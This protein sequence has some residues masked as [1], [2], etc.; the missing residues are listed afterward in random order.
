MASNQGS[1]KPFTKLFSS[2]TSSS[3]WRA[4]NEVRL[5]WITMLAMADKDGEV[6]ASVG[7]LAD[8]AR[9]SRQECLS[10]LHALLSPDE[11]SR[12]KEHDGRRLEE[13][14]GGWRLLNYKKYRDLGRNEDRR[15]YFAEH[16]RKQRAVKSPHCPPL[17]T[18]GPQKSPIAEAEAEAE[19]ERAASAAT[20]PTPPASPDEKKTRNRELLAKALRREGLPAT[21]E[22]VQE[23]G[24]MLLGAGGATSAEDALKRLGI[25]LRKARNNG[26]VIQYAKH[27]A[28]LARQVAAS[29]VAKEAKGPFGEDQS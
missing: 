11:D 18:N 20:T 6:W 3:I 25:V 21:Q 22:A 8:L 26:I 14:D 29:I 17:S 19:R 28:E 7:G 9:V 2:I 5:V 23:W 12:T 27:A 13:I 4:P 1:M 16:K 15:E 24:D 10:A